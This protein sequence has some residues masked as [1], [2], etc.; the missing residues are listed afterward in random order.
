MGRLLPTLLV[1]PLEAW[2]QG[3]TAKSVSML[4]ERGQDRSIP[5]PWRRAR[6]ALAR[7]LRAEKVGSATIV[8]T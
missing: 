5:C 2:K 7:S 1:G 6:I 8:L 3:A 4:A